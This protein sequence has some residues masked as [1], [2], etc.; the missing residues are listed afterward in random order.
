[1]KDKIQLSLDEKIELVSF[2]IETAERDTDT[3]NTVF[4]LLICSS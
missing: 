3:I 2:S 1:M 4:H